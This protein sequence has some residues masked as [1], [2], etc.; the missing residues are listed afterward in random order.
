MQRI[1]YLNNRKRKYNSTEIYR[2]KSNILK[3][4]VNNSFKT[5]INF[6][7]FIKKNLNNY[8]NV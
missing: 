5:T 6:L 2:L 1:N 8:Q 7:N 3:D 4:I